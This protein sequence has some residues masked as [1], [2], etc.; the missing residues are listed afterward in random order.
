MSPRSSGLGKA[1]AIGRVNLLRQARDRSSLF[2][3][4]VLPTII[5]LALGLQFA[6]GGRAR[7]GVVSPA[8]DAL[9]AELLE[10]LETAEAGF[11]VRPVADVATLR[12]QVERGFVE[13]GV[14]VP[15][16]YGET[17]LAGRQV[18][19]E[20]LGTPESTTTGIRATVDAAFGRQAAITL[21]ARIAAE[22]GPGSIA[23]ARDAATL[24][25]G[26]VPGVAVSVTRIGEPAPFAGVGQYEFGAQT[27]L[28]LFMFL[29]SMTSAAGLVLTRQLGVSRRMFSTPTTAVTII[30]GEAV[31]RFLVALLQGVYIVAV[32]ALVFGVRWGDPLAATAL[33]LAFG[34][35]CAAVA[36]LVGAISRNAD[37]AGALGVGA[38]LGMG[39]LGGAM[40]PASFM[41]PFML[42]IAQGIPHYW[43]ID[44]LGRLSR[45]A[46]L[47]DIALDIGVLAAMGTLIMVLA[48]WRYRRSLTG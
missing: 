28:V 40:V 26:S 43:A 46:S 24:A 4:F 11:D 16:G 13:L 48:A 21:A 30:A 22:L 5:V 8:G 34:L 20:I 45:G 44:G 15:D 37:Q 47:A 2:F 18:R 31:G 25:Y 27:Q 23:A 12:D 38:G 1:L 17:L 41:P 42:T 32:S 29:T 35:V 10:A 39:A 14:V 6:G 7:V 19:V 9:A 33:V 36:L 3:V